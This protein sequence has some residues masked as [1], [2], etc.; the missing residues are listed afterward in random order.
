MRWVS[1]DQK[2]AWFNNTAMDGTFAPRGYEP[3]QLPI[4]LGSAGRSWFGRWRNRYG[5]KFRTTVKHLKV[6]WAKLRQRVR[7]YLKNVFA[8]RL[9]WAKCYPDRPMRWVSWDQKPA[10]F[11]NTAMDGTFAPRGYEPTIREV[12]HHSRQRFTI[13]TGVDSATIHQ[14]I[15]RPPA[16]PS[17]GVLFKGK[18]RGAVRRRA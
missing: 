3:T 12:V 15:E 14:P 2:P 13:C 9:L 11:N 18:A 6:S 1:W 5:V 4:L 16:P 10:W 8:L 17:V 7:V